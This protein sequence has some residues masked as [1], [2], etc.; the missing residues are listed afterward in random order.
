LVKL[1]RNLGFAGGCNVGMKAA[2]AAGA[3]FVWLL[4]NDTVVEPHAASVLIDLAR[5]RPEANFFGSLICLAAEPGL[6]WFG[7]GDF[8]WVTGTPRHVG[9]RQPVSEYSAPDPVLTDWISGCSLLVRTDSLGSIGFMDEDLFLYMEDLDW[10]LRAGRGR[11]VA[12]L[13]RECLVHHK[14]GRSSGSTNDIMGRLFMSRNFLK[15]TC[16]YAGPRLPIWLGRWAF[17]FLVKPALKGDLRLVRAGFAGLTT[18]RTC[19]ADIV[20][21]WHGGM[22]Q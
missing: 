2:K 14:V 4:N 15:L 13:V 21:R 5:R 22:R 6:L 16:R 19:G 8:D 7:G 11:H 20:A 9:F 10:Q 17:E 18:Q 12:W 3:E 1:D